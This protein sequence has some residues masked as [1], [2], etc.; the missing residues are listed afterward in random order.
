MGQILNGSATTTEAVRRAIQTHQVS[1]RKLGAH[2]GINPKTVPKGADAVRS[3]HPAAAEERISVVTHY[4]SHLS[5]AAAQLDPKSPFRPS[6][7]PFAFPSLARKVGSLSADARQQPSHH[8][9]VWVTPAALKFVLLDGIL[10]EGR[11]LLYCLPLFLRK[12]HPLTN[13]SCGGSRG[14]PWSLG[15]Y[16]ISTGERIKKFYSFQQ[17]MYGRAR[18]TPV[19][20]TLVRAGGGVALI[21]LVNMRVRLTKPGPRAR[22]TAYRTPSLWKRKP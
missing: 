18:S 5:V 15:C 6:K 14:R 12:R 7:M 2:C 13:D 10:S 20:A 1:L 3:A 11:R 21:L 9:L 8:P 4:Y 22:E 16:E 17:I 19:E